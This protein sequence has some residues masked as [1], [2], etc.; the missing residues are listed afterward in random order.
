MPL[1]IISIL[2]HVFVWFPSVLWFGDGK[3]GIKA[4]TEPG[5]LFTIMYVCTQTFLP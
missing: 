2:T 1:R 3:E 4:V 5:M